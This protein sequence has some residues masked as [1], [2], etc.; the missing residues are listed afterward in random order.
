MI[1][2]FNWIN[3]L[4]EECYKLDEVE[5]KQRL[6]DLELHMIPFRYNLCKKNHRPFRKSKKSVSWCV[7][8]RVEMTFSNDEY[9][10]TIDRFQIKKN[11]FLCLV[12]KRGE[13]L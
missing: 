5:K 8:D 7:G 11:M 13:V 10:R 1:D 12:L 6:S 4:F 9:D 3:N 2:F